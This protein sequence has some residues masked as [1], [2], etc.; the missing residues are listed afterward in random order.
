VTTR[1]TLFS[2]L[3]ALCACAVLVGSALALT[4]EPAAGPDPAVAEWPEWPHRVSCGGLRFDP[5]V[6]F[7][8]P[9]G[10]EGEDTPQVRAMERFIHAGPPEEEF[11][12]KRDWRLL[13]EEDGWA[14]FG[15]GRLPE[16]MEWIAVE[17]K[18][19]RW[20]FASYSS[21]CEPASMRR[22][23]EAITWTLASQPR[24]R[25]RTRSILVELGPG[26][27]SS[28]RPQAPRL[29]KPEFREQNGALLISLWLRPL[30]PGGYTC[31]GIVEP[32]VRIR[33]PEPLGKRRL[34]D[35][36]T[37]PPRVPRLDFG[38]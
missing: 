33:L 22:G 32:P 12:R 14:E 31:E 35:G 8:S 3:A 15:S 4:E 16:E 18:R 27:C 21:G 23:R 37:Y 17:R 28:G 10:V 20:D 13:A 1:R 6:A 24:L 11:T 30:P 34:F 5:I 25:P 38:R 19:G 2:C 7:S 9:T 36:G 29:Q 26:E